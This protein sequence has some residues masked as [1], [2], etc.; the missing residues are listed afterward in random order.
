MFIIQ[1]RNITA[2]IYLISKKKWIYI[3]VEEEKHKTYVRNLRNT[4]IEKQMEEQAK[5]RVDE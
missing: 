2:I 3:G 4:R 5:E 1:V